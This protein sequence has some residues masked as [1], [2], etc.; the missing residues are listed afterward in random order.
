MLVY[1]CKVTV[2]MSF[3][4]KLSFEESCRWYRK[5]WFIALSYQ[6]RVSGFFFHI[7]WIFVELHK[8]SWAK[9]LKCLWWLIRWRLL[10]ILIMSEG[11]LN[12]VFL[13]WLRGAATKFCFMIA[14]LSLSLICFFNILV[15]ESVELNPL[16]AWF[17]F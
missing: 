8:S 3:F 5:S 15:I 17:I 4:V 1:L 11:K 14:F 9:P 7:M 13:G 2:L 10:N 16:L 6:I 12:S